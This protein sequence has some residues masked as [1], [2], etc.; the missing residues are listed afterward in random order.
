[1]PDSVKDQHKQ[2]IADSQTLK[3]NER[4]AEASALATPVKPSLLKEN[5]QSP[6]KPLTK[7][8]TQA[9]IYV[10]MIKY[11]KPYWWMFVLGLI[12]AIPSGAMDGAIAY[13]AGQGLQKILVEGHENLIYWVPLAVLIIATS[14]GVFRF[15]ESYCI[16]FVGAAAIRDLR[17]E[18]F[19]HL[20][21]Q[22]LLYFQG[23]SS[24]VLI[25]RMIN[26]VAVVENAISQTFQSM[27][28]RMITLVSLA[29][30][31]ILQSWWLAI[32]ALSILS[33]IVL[34]VGILGRKIRK[35]SRRSQ[36][37][38][39]DLVSVLSESIQGAKIVQSFNLEQFQTSKF[40]GTN[41]SFFDNTVKAPGKKP[42][43]HQF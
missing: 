18:L 3:D 27:I 38:I 11:I 23:Q 21:K 31:V 35:S 30:V 39:G 40:H 20:E 29:V 22:P 42:F 7:D 26:D 1:M 28:S 19:S 36:E 4:E 14:Q 10:R 12:A 15:M 9:Q 2:N 25:G 24:G 37:A 16:R 13:L 5:L 41:Q 6:S 33:C 17:N 34:P 8:P 32:V 43:C